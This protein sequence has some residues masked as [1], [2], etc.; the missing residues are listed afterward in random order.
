MS[1]LLQQ[2]GDDHPEA[3]GKHLA[4]SQTLLQASC[5][6]GAAYLAGHVLECALQSLIIAVRE[7]EGCHVSRLGGWQDLRGTVLS[8]GNP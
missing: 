1:Q 7:H 2:N 8:R 3:E 5:A 4:D 6:D